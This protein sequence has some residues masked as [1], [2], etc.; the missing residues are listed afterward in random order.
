MRRNI[1]QPSTLGEKKSGFLKHSTPKMTGWSLAHGFVFLFF[2]VLV[3]PN[4]LALHSFTGIFWEVLWGRSTETKKWCPN[5]L[6]LI[7]NKGLEKSQ[8]FKAGLRSYSP[9]VNFKLHRSSILRNEGMIL[10]SYKL[11]LPSSCGSH[12]MKLTECR[13]FCAFCCSN[14]DATSES[15][16]QHV[17]CGPQVFVT[18]G[19]FIETTLE[20]R[21]YATK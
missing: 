6:I 20:G 11:H 1:V 14:D 15:E 8:A 2:M 4:Q 12:D 5:W 21:T 9:T 16:F 18:A 7:L 17:F 19:K 3:W 10:T 13:Y